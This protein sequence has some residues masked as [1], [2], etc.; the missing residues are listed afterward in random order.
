[1]GFLY[2]DDFGLTV[3][4]ERADLRVFF[5]TNFYAAI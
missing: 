5:T 2:H 1:M 3:L 4:W